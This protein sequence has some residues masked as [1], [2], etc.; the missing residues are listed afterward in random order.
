MNN[1]KKREI[2]FIGLMLFALFFGAGNLIFPPFLGQEAGNHYWPAIMGFVLTGVGLPVLGV[3]AIALSGNSVETIAKHVGFRFAIVFTLLLYM[4]IGPF[5]GVPR[6]M[7]VSFEMGIVPFLSSSNSQIALFIF[8]VIF[9][10]LVYWVSLNPTKLVER[11]GN[12]ISPILLVAIA[13]LAGG[14]VFSGISALERT[15]NDPYV[16]YPSAGG[17]L[18]GYL[19]MDTIA[20]LAFGLVIVNAI[21]EKGVTDNNKLLRAVSLA[22]IIAGLGLAVVYISIGWIGVQTAATS[23]FENGSLIL[24]YAAAQTFGMPGAFLLGIIVTLAC[25]TTCVGLVTACGQYFSNVLPMFSYRTF[26]LLTVLVSVTVANL[27]LDAIISISAPVL[28]TIYP[29][30]I[31]LILL[32]FLQLKLPLRPSHYQ[33]GVMGAAIVSIYDGIREL[34]IEIPLITEVYSHLPLFSMGLGWILPVIIGLAA[35]QLIGCGRTSK[36]PQEK[37]ER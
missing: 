3:I 7:N 19:T 33:G 8:S 18:E 27:G 31:V 21:K 32:S 36:N 24:S 14:S 10:I 23:T 20:A 22:G 28:I 13:L 5:F 16:D 6:A 37:P 35:G 29:V 2:I 26:V 12:V 15:P 25:F 4:S 17:I 9:F 1:I 11:I 30:A 34:G